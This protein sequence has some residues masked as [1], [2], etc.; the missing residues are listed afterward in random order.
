MAYIINGGC[1]DDGF[2]YFL[3]WLI[4]KGRKY[5]EAAL[6]NPERAGDGAEPGDVVECEDIW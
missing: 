1:S 6:V 5:F 2:D 4:A 3:G